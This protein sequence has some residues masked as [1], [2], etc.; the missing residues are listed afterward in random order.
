MIVSRKQA[1]GR[2][3]VLACDGKCEKAWGRNTRPR[4]TDDEY[5]ADDELG[6]APA[7]PGTYEGEDSKPAA[8][9]HNRWCFREC[10]RS[11]SCS[12]T[13][14]PNLALPTF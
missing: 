3:I 1:F 10:E 9:Q 6:I 11:T 5:L 7:D 2:K 13:D 8:Q 4:R 12:L 14:F